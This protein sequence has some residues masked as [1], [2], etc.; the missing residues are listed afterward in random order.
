MTNYLKFFTLFLMHTLLFH[1]SAFQ[2]K[3]NLD[4]KVLLFSGTTKYLRSF[5]CNYISF[6][7]FLPPPRKTHIL[8]IYKYIQGFVNFIKTI[9]VNFDSQLSSIILHLWIGRM[10]NAHWQSKNERLVL[11]AEP[12]FRLKVRGE[13]LKAGI[14]SINS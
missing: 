7:C 9:N 10:C 12:L 11:A 4:A 3:R 5:F 13:R 2:R 6:S 8:L 14:I 1:A